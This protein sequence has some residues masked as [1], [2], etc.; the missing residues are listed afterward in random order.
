M[1]RATG[2][3]LG[4]LALLALIG[5]A[6]AAGARERD[7]ELPEP[8]P[9]PEPEP[10]PPAGMTQAQAQGIFNQAQA[11]CNVERNRE[12]QEQLAENGFNQLAD[13]IEEAIRQY[14]LAI[15][16]TVGPI[17]TTE[18]TVAAS[19]EIVGRIGVLRNL[20]FTC[21]ADDIAVKKADIIAGPGAP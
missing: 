7:E 14:L 9:E 2:A 4:G 15:G 13:T 19:G 18:E 5:I 21:F 17:A 11:S 12:R 10:T 20:G 6:A 16:I 8:E 1:A 3:L